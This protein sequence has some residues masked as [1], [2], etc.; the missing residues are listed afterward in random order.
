MGAIPYIYV[1][2]I[3]FLL[4]VW[5]VGVSGRLRVWDLPISKFQAMCEAWLEIDTLC[6][7]ARG[8]GV[9]AIAE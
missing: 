3:L 9:G 1:N 7:W 6:W 2:R 5:F 8:S 4:R